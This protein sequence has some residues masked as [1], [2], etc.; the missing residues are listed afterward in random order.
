MASV[1]ATDLEIGEFCGCDATTIA[2]RFPDV[3]T[4][5]RSNMRTKLRRAQY[6]A[7]MKG[8]VVMLIWLGKQM[9]G[10]A[11]KFEGELT[12]RVLLVD[13]LDQVAPTNRI[14][15]GKAKNGKNG[16]HA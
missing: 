12:G 9:L 1:G 13:R 8:N 5:A 14:T 16:A 4:K 10:Q 3:L 2:A 15:N 6:R 7:A 11:E